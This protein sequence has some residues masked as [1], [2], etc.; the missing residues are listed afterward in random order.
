MKKKQVK[1]LKIL[2]RKQMIQR[3]STGLALIKQVTHPKIY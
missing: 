3:L 1:G 2:T